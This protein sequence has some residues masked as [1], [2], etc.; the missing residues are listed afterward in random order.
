MLYMNN[1][2][3]NGMLNFNRGNLKNYTKIL[4]LTSNSRGNILEEF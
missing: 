4:S 1:I 3:K 2:W